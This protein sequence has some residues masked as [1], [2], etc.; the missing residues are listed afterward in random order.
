MKDYLISLFIDNELNLDEKIDF[1][2]NTHGDQVFKDEAIGLLK[3]EKQL[4]AEMVHRVPQVQA[5]EE[6]EPWKEVLFTWLRPASLFAAGLALGAA[7]LWVRPSIAPPPVLST[8]ANV[9]TPYRFVI[10]RPD[11]SQADIIGTFTGWQPVSME[12][13]GASGYWSLTLNLGEGEYQYSY[14]V[15]D[16]QQITDPTVPERVKDDFGGENSVITIK[17]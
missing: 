14:V 15:E 12:K 3:Q 16:G 1:V 4:H 17:V 5:V 6:K 7:L 8:V 11:A 10:Y 9:E 2:E 13:I